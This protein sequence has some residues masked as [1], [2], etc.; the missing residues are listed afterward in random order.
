MTDSPPDRR[1][2][3][4]RVTLITAAILSVAAAAWMAFRPGADVPV[5]RVDLPEM[6][7]AVRS[8]LTDYRTRLENN[9]DSADAWGLYG[10]CLQQHQR[11]REALAC[12]RVA[13][14]LDPKDARWPFY[15]GVIL[16][17][18]DTAQALAWFQE[19]IERDPRQ[20]AARLRAVELLIDT[21]R[22]DEARQLLDA[23][24]SRT[25]SPR[26]SVL[27]LRILRQSGQ[28]DGAERVLSEAR[29]QQR[30]SRELV[31]EAARIAM[32]DGKTSE[33]RAL[34]DEAATLPPVSA[35]EAEPVWLSDLRRFDVTGQSRSLEADRLR[36]QGDFQE[37]A[38]LLNR[39]TERFPQRSRP[40]LNHAT[41]LLEAGQV[42]AALQELRSLSTRFP[43]DPLIHFTLGRA[44][45]QAQ[46]PEVAENSIRRA[47]ELKPDFAAAWA[48]LADLCRQSE[49]FEEAD[50]AY[51]QAVAS[52]PEDATLQLAWAEFLIDRQELDAARRVL[53]GLR[54]L[55]ADPDRPPPRWQELMEELPQASGGDPAVPQQ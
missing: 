48:A 33:A 21:G 6:H 28:T 36:Q 3:V 38:R 5:P 35:I 22:T 52:A 27:R 10:M 45:Y 14:R 4:L 12:Y 54:A 11:P 30:L 31:S 34:M 13:A 18:T 42:R 25:A 7:P 32:M 50:R 15:S 1:R 47:L 55:F 24:D 23:G 46:Q 40:A 2:P 16:A 39:L 20:W 53:L 8:L 51:R 29:D 41:L 44:A 49:R 9:D 43:D 19:S 26:A 37:A 17:E